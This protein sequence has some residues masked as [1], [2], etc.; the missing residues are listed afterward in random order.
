MSKVSKVSFLSLKNSV[1]SFVFIFKNIQNQARTCVSDRKGIFVC[2]VREPLPCD[3]LPTDTGNVTLE[4]RKYLFD[5]EC[6]VR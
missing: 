4:R 6:V 3:L 2:A 5:L 1:K